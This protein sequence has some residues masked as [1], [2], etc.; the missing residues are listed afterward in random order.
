MNT[1]H[2]SIILKMEYSNTH[3]NFLDTTVYI[4][5]DTLQTSIYRKPTDRCNYL[6]SSSFHLQH[7]KRAIIHSQAIRYHRVCSDP[8]DRD[9]H[10]GT[11][12]DS[13]HK[14]ALQG[15]NYQ[16]RHKHS[17]ENTKR[18]STSVQREKNKQ[19]CTSGNHIQPSTRRNKKNNQRFTTHHNRGW[20]SE[21]NIPATPNT[22]LQTTPQPQK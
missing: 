5:D 19:P 3:V 22:G 16:H 10:L 4:R 9:K 2:P 13:F 20:N 11:L 18:K 12:A 15:Q 6:H 14:K 17:L 8:R 1:F 21:R 7:T